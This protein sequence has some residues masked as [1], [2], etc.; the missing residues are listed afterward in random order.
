[1]VHKEWDVTAILIGWNPQKKGA[2]Q[3]NASIT[4]QKKANK[5]PGKLQEFSI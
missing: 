5:I 4:D 3:C 2:K 1:M